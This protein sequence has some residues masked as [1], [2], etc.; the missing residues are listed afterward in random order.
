[1]LETLQ[2]MEEDT[3]RLREEI[4]ALKSEEKEL[5][6]SLKQGGDII[7]LPELRSTI[8]EME[9]QQ[10]EGEARL[11]KLESGNVKPVSA[12]DCR[13]VEKAYRRVKKAVVARKQMRKEV[14]KEIEEM[15]EGP[16]QK[17]ETKESMELDD[18]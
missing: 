15:L 7:P 17:Q 6:Q 2:R 11:K 14:W 13:R 9:K 18:L 16:E 5:R 8:A 10:A 1:M 12:A 3:K 4:I